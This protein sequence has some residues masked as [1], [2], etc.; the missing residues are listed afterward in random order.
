MTLRQDSKGQAPK[1]QGSPNAGP[2]SLNEVTANK[3]EANVSSYTPQSL[4]NYRNDLAIKR[5]HI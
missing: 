4:A 1:A 3:S 2:G 5:Y